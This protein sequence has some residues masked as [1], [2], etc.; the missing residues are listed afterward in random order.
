MT[1]EDEAREFLLELG[2]PG[3]LVDATP[4]DEWYL[5]VQQQLNFGGPPTMSARHV[6]ERTGLDVATVRRIWQVNGFADPG[7]DALVFHEADMH[8]FELWPAGVS[9]F[10]E[11]MIV[12]Y[13]RA[14]GGAARALSDATTALFSDVLGPSRAAAASLKEHLELAVLGGELNR[15]VPD[16]AIRPL[17][18]HHAEASQRFSAAAG[19]WA[20]AELEL[21]VG[22]CDLVGST[23]LV[24]GARAAEF[25][26]AVMRF[27]DVAHDAANGNG[28]RVVKL[29]GDEVMIAGLDVACVEATFLELLRWVADDDVLVAARGGIAFGTVAARSGDLYGPM[30]HLAARLASMAEPGELL[31]ADDAGEPVVVRGFEQPVC[32]RRAT[33]PTAGSA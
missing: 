24:T 25:G 14:L 33:A 6:A 17:Y 8:L 28:G 1:E 10:G 26:R 4:Q 13:A 9:V 19:A 30:V 29:I 23:E 15:R 22:F 20:S 27:E 12:R 21:A 11:E 7:D 31:V 3:E 5:L 18:F 2:V 32:V 16:E